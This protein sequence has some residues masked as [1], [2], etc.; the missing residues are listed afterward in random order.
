MELADLLHIRTNAAMKPG[1]KLQCYTV[2]RWNKVTKV[3]TLGYVIAECSSNL[4]L[5]TLVF[6]AV[7]L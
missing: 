6:S 5:F 4:E 2:R 3:E 1:M 7:Q